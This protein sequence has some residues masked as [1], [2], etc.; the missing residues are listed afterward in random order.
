MDIIVDFYSGSVTF[1][2]VDAFVPNQDGYLWI[3]ASETQYF[4]P[5]DT[6]EYFTVVDYSYSDD[7]DG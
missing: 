1:E 4:I 3:D 5:V 7:W 6:F 2:D